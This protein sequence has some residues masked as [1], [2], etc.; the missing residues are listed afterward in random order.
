MGRAG[1]EPKN[2]AGQQKE[3]RKAIQI[4]PDRLY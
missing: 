3:G 2:E 4:V 1:A